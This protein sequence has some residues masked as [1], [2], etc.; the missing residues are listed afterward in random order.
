MLYV[1]HNLNKIAKLYDN[2]IKMSISI[3]LWKLKSMIPFISGICATS[4]SVLN[5]SKKK[6]AFV[7]TASFNLNKWICV[8]HAIFYLIA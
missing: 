4:M 6:N 1:N 7:S 3:S 8:N 5:L 2:E